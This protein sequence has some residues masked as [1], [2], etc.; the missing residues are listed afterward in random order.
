MG[1]S[2]A[3]RKRR[4]RRVLELGSAGL[5]IP[6]ISD[7]MKKEGYAASERTVWGDLNGVEAKEYTAEIL[8]KQLADISIAEIGLRLKYRGRLLDKLM[9]SKV[10]QKIEGEIRKYDVEALLDRALKQEE[11]LEKNR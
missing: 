5:T 11:L 4:V 6:D 1:G 7:M 9:P 8:R 10:E 3:Q 2:K